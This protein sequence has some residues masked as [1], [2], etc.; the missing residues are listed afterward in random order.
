MAVHPRTK[1][2][3]GPGGRPT[4][5]D[6]KYCEQILEYFERDPY[7]ERIK[8]I[9]TKSGDV[10]EVPVLEASDTPTLAGFA[11]S[12]GVHRDT[13]KEWAK[14]HPEF[15]A[16]V[17]KAKEAQENFIVTNGMKGLVNTPFAI[18]LAKNVCGYRDN[19]DVEV[20]AEVKSTTEE[21]DSLRKELE[22]LKAMMKE[23]A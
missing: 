16:S 9:V 7:T 13:L 6:P 19:R 3:K 2:A 5:Y 21:A 8:K 23:E 15:S 4:D 11:V 18:F 17:K 20:K 12:I 10:V 1:Q 22:S 14:V